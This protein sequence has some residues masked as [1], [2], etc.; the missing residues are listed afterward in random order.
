MI[1][2]PF[3]SHVSIHLSSFACDMQGLRAQID[4]DQ[5]RQNMQEEISS[6]K[7]LSIIESSVDDLII[8]KDG[9][10]HRINSVLLGMHKA[11]IH[12]VWSKIMSEHIFCT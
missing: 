12:A 11:Y 4:R 10:H 8:I 7:N 2:Y 1:F 6:T 5:Y 9:N 3:L